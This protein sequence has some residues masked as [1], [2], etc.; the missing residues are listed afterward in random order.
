[1]NDSPYWFFTSY[2]E[3]PEKHSYVERF[4]QDVEDEVRAQLG[5]QTPGGAFLDLRSIDPGNRW[6]FRIQNGVCTARTMLVLYCASYFQSEWCAREW[7]VFAERRRRHREGGGPDEHLIGVAWRRGPMSW[8]EVADDDQHLRQEFGPTYAE[9]GLFHLVPE[10]RKPGSNEYKSIVRKVATRLAAT[11]YQ[12]GDLPQVSLVEA[13]GLTPLFGPDRLRPV[14]VVISYT[15]VELDSAWGAWATEQ[16]ELAGYSVDAEVI[17]AADNGTVDRVRQ[18]L[19][20][21]KKV[22]V[23]VSDTFFSCGDMTGAA[24]DT[25]LSDGSSDWQRLIPVFVDTPVEGTN[26]AAFRQFSD[27]PLGEL[28]EE[29]ATEVLL[30]AAQALA[31]YSQQPPAQRAVFP[32]KPAAGAPVNAMQKVDSL[33]NALKNADSVSDPMIRP[34]WIT[35]TGIDVGSLDV[36]RIPLRPLLYALTD[37]CADQT[38]GY[39][40][41]ADALDALDPGSP[42]GHRVRQAVERLASGPQPG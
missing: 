24:L 3:L 16:L 26:P 14:D 12:G 32:R 31:R 28:D 11:I 25:A 34:I 15:D 10:E 37:L 35:R 2:S 38:G 1:M 21:A 40:A 29:A 30:R 17:S 22:L 42:A 9:Y 27:P 39:T 18:S 41:L 8:P 33:V 36:A 7:T 20:R 6:R 5:K 19:R 4:H 13:R 23:L